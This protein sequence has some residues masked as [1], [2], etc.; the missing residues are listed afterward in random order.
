[1]RLALCLCM[2]VAAMP[3]A[4]QSPL[5][6]SVEVVD[7]ARFGAGVYRD[8]DVDRPANLRKSP[9]AAFEFPRDLACATVDLE[10]VVDESGHPVSEHARVV[11]TSY[12]DFAR[13]TLKVLPRWEYEPAM[14]DGAAVRQVVTAHVARMPERRAFVIRPAPGGGPALPPCT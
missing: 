5:R 4:A 7:T 6:C 14:K 9:R 12:R 2:I 11:A 10:F 3:L 1:M 8:C 13:A